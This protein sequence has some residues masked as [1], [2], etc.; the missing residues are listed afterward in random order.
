MNLSQV[1]LTKQEL[2][3]LLRGLTFCPIPLKLNHTELRADLADFICRLRLQEYF[4]DPSRSHKEAP[5]FCNKSS[6]TP[7][8]NWEI[9]LEAFIKAVEEV[10]NITPYKIGSNL[11]VQEKEALHNLMSRTDIIIKPADKGSATVV[12]DREWYLREC[13]RQL[14]N[15]NFCKKTNED[16]ES[17]HSSKTLC[18]QFTTRWFYR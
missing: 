7:P 9:A 5:R 4:Y 13:Y 12:M 14:E 2:D 6:S 16:C 18:G 8:H 17:M 3:L 1:T 11:T 15:T 10:K